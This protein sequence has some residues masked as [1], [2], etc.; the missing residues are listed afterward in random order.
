[1]KKKII[2]VVLMIIMLFSF[3]VCVFSEDEKTEKKA[4]ASVQNEKNKEEKKDAKKKEADKEKEPAVK[5]SVSANSPHAILLDMNTGM[6]IYEKNSNKR[7]YPAD[8]TKIMTAVLVLEN[9]KL[10][11]V[12]AAN[13]T[14]LTN[15]KTGDSKLGILKEEK[16]S[17]RQLLYAM[18]LGSAADAT[19]VLAEKTS[20]SIENF[21]LLMNQKAKGLGMTNTNFTNPSGDHDERHYTTAS[22]MAKLT[23]HAMKNKDFREIVKCDSYSIG[24]TQKNGTVRKI[25]NRNHFV[26][27]L[28]RADY[29]YEYSTGIKSGYSTDAKSCIAA[30]AEK[31]GMSLIALVFGAETVDNVVQSFTDCKTLFEY[32]F[33]NYERQNINGKGEII[34]QTELVN[35]RRNNK[36]ILKAS[37]DFSVL[38]EKGSEDLKITYR[39][40]L[41]KEKS[42][43][44]K[45]GEVIGKRVFY[46][47][48]KRIGDIKLLADKDYVL[49][50]VTFIVNKIVAFFTSPWLFVVIALVLVFLI[51]M[52]RRRR[53]IL[54]KKRREARKRRNQEMIEMI[55]SI[56]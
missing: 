46:L 50:P 16:L 12:T 10:E 30:S 52:E 2:S 28:I 27:K 55:E 17:V 11:E 35:T 8:L 38:K 25:T 15:V 44:I 4:D 23:V 21:V 22:D 48:N 42:A 54:R 51:L 49:D 40:D 3:S 41:P 5:E 18:L 31:N 1:M 56:R 29:Y 39:D 32:A 53:R 20:G 43:P 36:L 24:A 19:N 37:A 6:V 47:N 14:A 26:S 33:K 7:V 13:E 34:S 9:C 45:E